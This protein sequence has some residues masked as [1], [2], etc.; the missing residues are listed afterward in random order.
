[1]SSIECLPF[2]AHPLYFPGSNS[3]EDCQTEETINNLSLGIHLFT[4]SSEALFLIANH[5]QD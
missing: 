2:Q 5:R 1:L 4:Y 3:A